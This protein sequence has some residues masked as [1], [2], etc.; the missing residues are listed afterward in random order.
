M[1]DGKYAKTWITDQR[2]FDQITPTY[3]PEKFDILGEKLDKAFLDIAD[4]FVTQSLNPH[5]NDL[6]VGNV[7][8]L[9]LLNWV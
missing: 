4:T 6:I 2:S 8:V 9:V 5:L 3:I 1:D 7:C